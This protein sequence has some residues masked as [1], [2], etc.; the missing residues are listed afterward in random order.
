MKLYHS[1][2][3]PQ[4]IKESIERALEGLTSEIKCCYEVECVPSELIS[5]EGNVLCSNCREAIHVGVLSDEENMKQREIF[6]HYHEIRGNI[7]ESKKIDKEDKYDVL[8]HIRMPSP[9][10]KGSAHKDKTKY[11]R[12]EKHRKN[13]D[14]AVNIKKLVELFELE[15]EEEECPRGYHKEYDHRGKATG[16]CIKGETDSGEEVSAALRRSL[17]GL[18]EARNWVREGFDVTIDCYNASVDQEDSLYGTF[19]E[20]VEPKETYLFEDTDGIIKCRNCLMDIDDERFS[21]IHRLP[22]LVKSLNEV[23]DSL[24]EKEQVL[25]T[26]KNNEDEIGPLELENGRIYCSLCG[27]K[28][29]DSHREELK[30]GMLETKFFK[31]HTFADGKKRSLKEIISEIIRKVGSQYVLYSKKKN[32]KTGKRRVLGRGSKE[33]MKKREQQVNYFKSRG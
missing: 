22:G 17:R 32:P 30:S 31:N 18:N 14:E 2:N 8:R 33:Q 24:L 6:L 4:D 21:S 27:Q 10:Q 25:V 3:V 11:S 28:L 29:S 9:E 26:C 20:D 16:E 1:T 5:E 12:K 19:D 13:F 7:N 23:N 15:D